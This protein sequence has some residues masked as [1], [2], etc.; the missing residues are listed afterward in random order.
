MAAK[1]DA[2]KI[3]RKA[4]GSSTQTTEEPQGGQRRTTTLQGNG[5]G[6][7]RMHPVGSNPHV[8]FAAC[9]WWEE[10]ML[11]LLIVKLLLLL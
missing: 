10:A 3:Y 9:D 4:T 8:D 6:D 5:V 7:K 2:G 1:M 11:S